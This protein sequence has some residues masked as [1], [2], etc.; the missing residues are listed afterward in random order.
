VDD[1][2]DTL[3]ALFRE[4]AAAHH[5]AFV[6]ADGH[7]PEWPI[8]YA[9]YLEPRLRALGWRVQTHALADALRDLDEAHRASGSEVPWPDFYARWLVE[10]LRS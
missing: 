8:W 1:S 5:E 2:P 9:R 10:Y 4:A 3:V 7:D 6:A